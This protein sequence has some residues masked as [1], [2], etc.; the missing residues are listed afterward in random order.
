MPYPVVFSIILIAKTFNFDVYIAHFKNNWRNSWRT[1][2][3]TLSWILSFIYTMHLWIAFQKMKIRIFIHFMLF[4]LWH[5]TGKGNSWG[6][7]SGSF[8]VEVRK[9]V[10]TLH[11][12]PRDGNNRISAKY[13]AMHYP[14]MSCLAISK[15][16]SSL[17]L[18]LLCRYCIFANFPSYLLKSS[19]GP[20]K[21]MLR[22][23]LWE[24]SDFC[25]IA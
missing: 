24:N 2:T 16:L 8:I 22:L 4:S 18:F 13:A 12:H 11:Q 3:Y 14:A 9:K 19:R 10:S 6:A 20:T 21:S 23:L 25:W 15:M 17:R 1:H 7:D 5:D